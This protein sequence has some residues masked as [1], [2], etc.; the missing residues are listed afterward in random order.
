MEIWSQNHQSERSAYI[1]EERDREWRH[2]ARAVCSRVEPA[3][4]NELFLRSAKQSFAIINGRHGPHAFLMKEHNQ[5]VSRASLIRMR[6][7]RDHQGFLV[8]EE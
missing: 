7:M 4:L 1:V 8:V 6:K 3:N 5:R 2:L